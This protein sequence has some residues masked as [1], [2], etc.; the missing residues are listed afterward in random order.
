[1]KVDL[2]QLDDNSFTIN[3]RGAVV[4]DKALL[5]KVPEPSLIN[6]TTKFK[7]ILDC[8][9]VLVDICQ[10][11]MKKTIEDDYLR[12]KYLTNDMIDLY[13]QGLIN[14]RV[15]TYLTQLMRLTSNEDLIR[16]GSLYKDDP[17]FYDDLKPSPYFK[18]LSKILNVVDSIDVITKRPT[19]DDKDTPACISKKRFLLKAFKAMD[20][21]TTTVNFHFLPYNKSKADYIIENDIKFTCFV[22]DLTEN[23]I[24]IVKKYPYTGY[25]ILAPLTGYNSDLPS[26]LLQEEKFVTGKTTFL[27]F[28][29]FEPEIISGKDLMEYMPE[30][31]KIKLNLNK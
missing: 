2:E 25:E 16:W 13:D 4:D 11:W 17:T 24:D 31:S 23:I 29:N 18:S 7:L 3:N 28:N 30:L 1:M 8:D 10:K 6:G 20:L 14:L 9:E 12:N 26:K 19:E 21:K 15:H 27:Q 5:A 22:D